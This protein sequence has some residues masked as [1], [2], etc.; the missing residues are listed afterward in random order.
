ML[1]ILS[2]P[3]EVIIKIF[4]YLSP[5]ETQRVIEVFYHSPKSHQLLELLYRRLFSGKLMLIN[6]EPKHKHYPD[7]EL[8]LS[9]FLD[10][11]LTLN[12]ENRLF[13]STRPNKIEF[14]FTRQHCDYMRFISNLNQFHEILEDPSC[15]EYFKNTLQVDVY[16]DANLV[17]IENPDNLTAVIIKVILELS[18]HKEFVHKIQHLT[19]KASDIGNMYV[20]QWSLLFTNFSS[21]VSLDLSQNLLKSNYDQYLDLWG[22]SKKFPS[23]L[24]KLNLDSNMLTYVSKEFIKNL[25]DS[26]EELLMN[27]NDIEIIELCDLG[28][29]LP[30][31]KKWELNYTKLSIMNPLTFK[32]CDKGFTLELVSTYLPVTD[33]EKLKK[34]AHEKR[35][36]VVI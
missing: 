16:V 6:D 25:P 18:K 7:C 19:I 21:L 35:F 27:Q 26:L 33:L 9:S 8:T 10:K 5:S 31:L 22:A 14:N 36:T 12:K 29:L 28:V 4:Q 32:S 15:Q 17:L 13:Q 24:K 20:P 3:N 2:L 30:N 1:T 34:I 11:F 23:F